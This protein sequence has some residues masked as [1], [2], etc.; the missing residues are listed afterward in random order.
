MHCVGSD[1]SVVLS[2]EEP[3][4]IPVRLTFEALAH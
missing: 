3:E 4:D 1:L 2:I